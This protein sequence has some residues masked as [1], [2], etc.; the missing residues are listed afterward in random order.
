MGIRFPAFELQASRDALA[1]LGNGITGFK[2]ETIG[3]RVQSLWLRDVERRVWMIAVDQRDVRPMFEVFTLGMQSLKALRKRWSEWTPPAIPVDMPAAFQQMMATR[4]AEPVA[5][6]DFQPWPFT[7]RQRIDVLRRSEFIVE[8]VDVIGAFGDHPNA[9]SAARPRSV[10]KEASASC[11]VAAG[12][13]FSGDQDQR[14]L[15]AV[16]WMPMNM[17]FTRENAR[18]DEYTASCERVSLAAY[19]VR[20]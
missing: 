6:D 1:A 9:Q 13:L 15:V 7:P 3:S 20:L 4:P 5:P 17:I 18:I 16:D 8:D 14:L 11:E 10:P 12:I 19:L 2:T